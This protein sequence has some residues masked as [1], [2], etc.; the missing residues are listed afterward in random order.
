MLR[1]A[2]ALLLCCSSVRS[3][4]SIYTNGVEKMASTGIV[5]AT[6]ISAQWQPITGVER[7]TAGPPARFVLSPWNGSTDPLQS[8]EIVVQG[9]GFG[10]SI[11]AGAIVTGI[12]VDLAVRQKTWLFEP[13]LAASIRHAKVATD[14]PPTPLAVVYRSGERVSPIDFPVLIPDPFLHI[15]YDPQPVGGPYDLWPTVVGDLHYSDPNEAE[16][17]IET[18]WNDVGSFPGQFLMIEAVVRNIGQ[19]TVE[20]EVSGVEIEVFYM[21]LPTGLGGR[22]A[23]GSAGTATLRKVRQLAGSSA[24]V[25]NRQSSTA[26]LGVRRTIPVFPRLVARSE[27]ESY[28]RATLTK[29]VGGTVANRFMN[30]RSSTVSTATGSLTRGPKTWRGLW[31]ATTSAATGFLGKMR[32][33]GGRSD[34]VSGG[35][36]EFFRTARIGGAAASTSGGTAALTRVRRLAGTSASASAMTGALIARRGVGGVAASESGGAATLNRLVKLTNG[37][38]S[39]VVSATESAGVGTVRRLRLFAPAVSASVSGG[40]VNLLNTALNPNPAMTLQAVRKARTFEP[41]RR[42]TRIFKG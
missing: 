30:G 23:T 27:T 21:P 24:T 34:T 31:S 11:P 3:S 33:I 12:R 35:I 22:S 26:F 19:T 36:V 14:E 5:A 40:T 13:L 9:S 37:G 38:A 18:Y 25:S 17:S 1:L 20:V 15:G 42:S 39:P 32:R 8:N 2:L 7:I 6:S 16:V 41:V 28:S 10:L 29:L 4:D